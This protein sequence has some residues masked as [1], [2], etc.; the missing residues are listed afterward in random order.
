MEGDGMALRTLH[1]FA[2][3]GGGILADFEQPIRNKIAFEKQIYEPRPRDLR[4]FAN[5]T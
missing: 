3:A 5:I 2:G 4:L 1:L